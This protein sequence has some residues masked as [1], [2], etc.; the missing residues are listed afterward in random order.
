MAAN[1]KP[2]YAVEVREPNPLRMSFEGTSR[3]W[4][5]M[6]AFDVL[7]LAKNEGQDHSS[8]INVLFAGKSHM[9]CMCFSLSDSRQPVAI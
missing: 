7:N 6:P 3:L 9:L 5:D 8:P 2:I 4:R 1:W